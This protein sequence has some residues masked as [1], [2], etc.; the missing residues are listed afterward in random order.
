[1]VVMEAI[2]NHD[3]MRDIFGERQ[4]DVFVASPENREEVY[5]HG[6]GLLSNKQYWGY[7]DGNVLLLYCE[8][9]E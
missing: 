8:N 3:E 6:A 9:Q 1:M 4:G 5:V 2:V 7:Q